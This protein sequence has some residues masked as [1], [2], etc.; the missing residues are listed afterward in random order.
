[1]L[2]LFCTFTLRPSFTPGLTTT[3][4]PMLQSSPIVQPGMMWLKCQIRVPLPI[5]QPSSITAVGCAVYSLIRGCEGTERLPS[6]S[7]RPDRPVFT[8][9]RSKLPWKPDHSFLR[10]NSF[11]V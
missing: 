6:G 8:Q 9:I 11:S 7:D 10:L 2:T 1:M 4:C 3:F 5:V